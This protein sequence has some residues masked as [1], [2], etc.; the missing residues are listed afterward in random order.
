[1]VLEEASD[2]T[3]LRLFSFFLGYWTLGVLMLKI[4][5]PGCGLPLR[6]LLSNSEVSLAGDE[7][8]GWGLRCVLHRCELE[9]WA[10]LL[11]W[12]WIQNLKVSF[13]IL[14]AIQIN[15]TTLEWVRVQAFICSVVLNNNNL[16]SYLLAV[17]SR[18]QSGMDDSYLVDPASSHM[19]VSK[20]KPCMSKYKQLY[21]VKLRTAHYISH[22]LF[23]GPLLHGY[24]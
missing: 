7:S 16:L 5:H 3:H 11:E 17:V 24:P 9:P 6:K 23:D 14:N 1:M 12:T 18:L 4:S 20:I 10:K 22:Y 8:L 13:R 2:C 19:L 15:L 21:T